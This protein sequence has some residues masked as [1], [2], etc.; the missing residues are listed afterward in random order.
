MRARWSMALVLAQVVTALT[1]SAA[2]FTLLGYFGTPLSI[3]DDGKVVLLYTSSA[4]YLLEDGVL[5]PL[6]SLPGWPADAQAVDM[7][8]DG[9][10]IAG[11]AATPARPYAYDEGFIWSG[12]VTTYLAID[13][14]AG[15]YVDALS[16]DGGTVAGRDAG[17]LY[18]WSAGTFT[19]LQSIVDA[20]FPGSLFSARVLDV[21]HDGSVAV[22]YNK[23]TN[24]HC[25][26][27]DWAVRW[28]GGSVTKLDDL[29]VPPPPNPDVSELM[30]TLVLSDDGLVAAGT[31]RATPTEPHHF[32][33]DP[34]GVGYVDDT[35]DCACA[36][37]DISRDGSRMVGRITPSSGAPGAG[38]WDLANGPRLVTDVLL[39]DFGVAVP[40]GYDLLRGYLI[41]ADGRTLVGRATPTGGGAELWIATLEGPPAVPA[42]TP[43]GGAAL[44]LLVGTTGAWTT[45]RRRS[46]A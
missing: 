29:L 19:P 11:N 23:V 17:G 35:A 14:T 32:R 12:G 7:S 40:A 33:I 41:S 13:G 26:Q 39:D 1:A 43:L 4:Y 28:D 6:S 42:L 30:R 20:G 46:P 37:Q 24:N 18:S 21:S 15:P 2:D 25:Y 34:T 5:T 27:C 36:V 22:G 45:A 8:G 44:A 31:V 38:L 10:V 16:G 9:Q 3:S